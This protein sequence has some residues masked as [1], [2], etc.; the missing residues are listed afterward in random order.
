[1]GSKVIRN[2]TK[3]FKSD[4]GVLFGRVS[5]GTGR[6]EELSPSQVRT[7]I[8]FDESVDDRVAALLAAGTNI[9][10]TYNDAANT[11]T[12]AST[13]GGLSGTGSVD[14]A[15]LRADGTGGATLQS[16]AFVI[17]DN[18]T[19]SPNNTVN[20]ASIQATGATTNVSVSIVPKGTGAFCLAVPDG[21]STGGNARGANAVDLQT[22]RSASTQVASGASST[23]I[24]GENG[25]ASGIRSVSIG[26][27]IA[28]ASSAIAIGSNGESGAASVASGLRSP[29]AMAGGSATGSYDPIAIGYA[30]VAT[31]TYSSIAIGAQCQAT[32]DNTSIA[33]GQS[34]IASG[35]VSIAMGN[36]SRADRDRQ[37][38]W[39]VGFF[40][41]GGDVQEVTFGLSNRTTDA[42][43]ITL[44]SNGSSTR[45]TIPSGKAMFC[46]IK[47]MGIKSD[48]SAAACYMR[49]V[50]IK[51]VGGATSLVGSVETIGTDIEDNASTDVAITADNTNDAL[52]IDV[53]GITGE[54]WRWAAVVDGLEIAYGT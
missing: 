45:L 28:T 29:I 9:T 1:M 4:S 44:F 8:D 35:T 6:G 41:V 31:G 52:R 38:A 27:G 36:G 48:G 26:G 5:A 37:K 10:I 53:T 32:G 3:V 16:S 49:K 21:T 12:I 42:T 30:T 19:T 2:I 50:A 40:G 23:L 54:T 34:A 43:P 13:A 51:N 24:G 18:A 20:H 15:V 46:T 17:A 11:L 39:A 33:I 47:I 7:L 22:A 25:T 14:N